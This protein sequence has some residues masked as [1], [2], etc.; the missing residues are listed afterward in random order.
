MILAS[1][2]LCTHPRRASSYLDQCKSKTI[3]IRTGVSKPYYPV[4]LLDK[5]SIIRHEYMY[6]TLTIILV[7]LCISACDKFPSALAPSGTISSSAA[8]PPLSVAIDSSRSGD[9]TNKL[10]AIVIQTGSPDQVV[11]SW[12]RYLD[13]TE[14]VST[15]LCKESQNKPLPDHHKY[16]PQITT[17]DLLAE[18]MDLKVDCVQEEFSREIKEVKSESETRALVF[19]IIKNATPIPPGAEPDKTDLK[20]RSDGFQFK[21]LVERDGNEWKI[22][23]VYRYDDAAEYLKKEPW[24]K[25]YS[26]SDKPHVPALVFIQ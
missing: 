2:A 9:S 23:Q 21:Y 8:P 25:I 4:K 7:S 5:I 22:A 16:I 24:E 18:R 1:L 26:T 20:W 11:K 6:K 15:K 13:L 12:W 19:A 3:E 10:E 14:A 17:G